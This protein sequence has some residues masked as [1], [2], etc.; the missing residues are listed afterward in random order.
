MYIKRGFCGFTK[1][2]LPQIVLVCIFLFASFPLTVYQ[3]YRLHENFKFI[4]TLMTNL[5]IMTICAG[6]FIAAMAIPEYNC[7]QIVRYLPSDAYALIISCSFHYPQVIRPLLDYYYMNKKANKLEININGLIQLLNDETLFN[8]FFEYCKQKCCV[9]NALFHIKYKKYKGLI[10]LYFKKVKYESSIPESYLARLSRSINRLGSADGYND[11][12]EHK[13]RD[14]N[15]DKYDTGSSIDLNSDHKSKDNRV[16]DP[17]YFKMREE[18]KRAIIYSDIHKLANTIYSSFLNDNAKYEINLSEKTIK[19]IKM[20][21]VTHNQ[22]Y[23]ASSNAHLN[24]DKIDIEN[25]YDEAYDEVLQVL[26][27]DVYTEYITN[28]NQRNK[29]KNT[30]T[31]FTA[32]ATN[33]IKDNISSNPNSSNYTSSNYISPEDNL[34]SASNSSSS[35]EIAN[36]K[37]NIIDGE[38]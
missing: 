38:L 2:Y 28:R 6:L 21:L 16:N 14:K 12:S 37:G 18:K 32:T 4:N 3:F 26:F 34:H 19:D 10:N 11:L 29:G 20:K 7:S 30:V 31:V 17:D 33:G 1:E 36:A 23:V 22:N 5:L 13:L 25:L 15:K 35:S 9:E 8:E 27:V 24:D